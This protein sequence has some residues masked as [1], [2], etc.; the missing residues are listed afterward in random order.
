VLVAEGVGVTTGE[1]ELAGTRA[2]CVPA[3]DVERGGLVSAVG[4]SVVAGGGVAGAGGDEAEDGAVA[5]VTP[6]V[7]VG[8][9]LMSR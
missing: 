3:G 4:L 6:V 5:G 8:G 1:G 2:G 9:G 7:A